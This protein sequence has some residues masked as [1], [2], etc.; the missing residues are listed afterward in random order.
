MSRVKSALLTFEGVVPAEQFGVNLRKFFQA[1]PKLLIGCHALLTLL[2]LSW[3]FKQELQNVAFGQ[4]AHQ[5]VEGAVFLSVGT[6]AVGLATGGEAFDVGGPQEVMRDDK[7]PQ[8]RGLALA[9][10]QSR[11]AAELVCLSQQLG[12]DHKTAAGGK[13]KENGLQLYDNA[14]LPNPLKTSILRKDRSKSCGI[15]VSRT[16]LNTLCFTGKWT[17][18]F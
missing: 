4:A 7:L 11:C 5:I 1:V 6:G 2:L 8:Q 17:F 12:E 10:R 3:A 15:A 13:K 18:R 14:N 9:Q 16:R